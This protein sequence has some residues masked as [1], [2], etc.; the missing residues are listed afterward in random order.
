[1]RLEPRLAAVLAFAVVAATL[2]GIL[3]FGRLEYPS[4]PSLAAEAEPS[5][6][7]RV[8]WVRW[9]REDGPCIWIVRA[10][11]GTPRSLRCGGTLGGPLS[12]GPDGTLRV[13]DHSGATAYEVRLDPDTGR[14]LGRDR[15]TRPD[16]PGPQPSDERGDG[17][18]VLAQS[19]DGTTSLLLIRPDGQER[20][21]ARV[22]GPRDY[23]WWAAQWGPDGRH[24]LVQ[25][26]AQRLL[27]VRVRDGRVWLLAEEGG[28]AAWGPDPS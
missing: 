11:G 3:L 20:T 15:I 22:D 17:T 16:L 2:G 19:A 14:V 9:E 23:N 5:I 28:D 26:S 27:V 25:D 13:P 18:R 24:V 10:S 7:G 21:I 1:M 12:W 6:P 8:A 4:Y